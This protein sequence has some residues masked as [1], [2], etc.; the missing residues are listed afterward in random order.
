VVLNLSRE[1]VR[2]VAVRVAPGQIESVT[3]FLQNTW[4][5][6]AVDQPL[7][8]SFLDED[9]ARL[10]HSDRRTGKIM[11]SFSVVSIFIACLGL[12]GLASFSAQQRT[13]EIGV[14]KVLGASITRIIFLLSKEFAQLVW[15]ACLVASV[16]AYYFMHQWLQNFAYR[17]E[18]DWWFFAL[19]GVLSFTVALLTVSYQA[20]RA[21]R[22][23]PVDSLRYE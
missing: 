13:K 11:A 21:A 19:A 23:N 17:I 20:I 7:E 16:P 9:F 22:A 14:R 5:K 12:F 3:A 8:Y 1:G 15:L 18:I 6:Y 10:Y 2:F 4:Q